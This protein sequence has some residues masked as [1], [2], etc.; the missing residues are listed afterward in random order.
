[1]S[2]DSADLNDV[3]E[4]LKIETQKYKQGIPP[5]KE[6][7]DQSPKHHSLTLMESHAELLKLEA[8]YQSNL[9]RWQDE[10]QLDVDK[11][12][13]LFQ[14]LSTLIK[15]YESFQIPSIKE[16]DPNMP[17]TADKPIQHVETTLN[18]LNTLLN[19]FKSTMDALNTC[20]Q[21]ATK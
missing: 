10:H 5:S 13:N 21:I 11:I 7:V 2:L 9:H 8:A 14:P 20:Q 4:K 1:M 19:T 6:T 18:I 15:L 16:S 17:K 12:S 3:L